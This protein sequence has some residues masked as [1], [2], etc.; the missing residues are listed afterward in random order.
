ME[1]TIRTVRAN[2]M[3]LIRKDPWLA[4]WRLASQ[5]WQCDS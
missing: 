5:E 3:A 2:L 1:S 4:D